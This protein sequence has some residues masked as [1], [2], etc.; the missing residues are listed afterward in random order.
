MENLRIIDKPSCQAYWRVGVFTVG[1]LIEA[2]KNNEIDPKTELAYN[3]VVEM[4]RDKDS[5]EEV[6]AIATRGINE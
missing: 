3:Y 5:E 4:W 6:M 1:E 2:I